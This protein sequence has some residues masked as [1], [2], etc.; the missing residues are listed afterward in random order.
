MYNLERVKKEFIEILEQAKVKYGN[1]PILINSRFS[2]TLGRVTYK[3]HMRGEAATVD[4][5]E[6]SK[7]LLD[8]ATDRSVRDVIEHEACHYIATKRSGI[9]RG[10]DKYFKSICA[11]IG[12]TN[13][14]TTTD[15]ERTVEAKKVFKYIIMCD[16][17]NEQVGQYM[18]RCGVVKD[19]SHYF[20]KK[21]KDHNLRVIQNF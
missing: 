2:H 1:E 8:T 5:I 3:R 9:V 20:C 11:E 10:H 6:F 13:D 14:K 12:C 17:C 19:P 15:V 7:Q 21:C 4:R 18:R 16:T